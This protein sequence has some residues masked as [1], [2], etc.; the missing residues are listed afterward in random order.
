MVVEDETSGTCNLHPMG[1]IT[2]IWVS[3]RAD[4]YIC[5]YI[6]EQRWKTFWTARAQTGYKF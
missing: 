3:N 1:Y 2:V 4:L 6:L 5:T